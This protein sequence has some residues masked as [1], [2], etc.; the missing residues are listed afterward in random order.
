MFIVGICSVLLGQPRSHEV[1]LGVMRHTHALWGF[2]V[3]YSLFLCAI[4]SF[5][6]KIFFVSG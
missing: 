5:N 6:A 4:A 3:F 2:F 1:S